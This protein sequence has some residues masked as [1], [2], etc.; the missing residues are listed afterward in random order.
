[1]TKINPDAK[2]PEGKRKALLI[3]GGVIAFV[4]FVFV[5]D[6]FAGLGLVG[7]GLAL[8]SG[9]ESPTTENAANDAVLKGPALQAKQLPVA[10]P[11]GEIEGDEEEEAGD[12]GE[13]EEQGGGEEEGDEEEDEQGALDLGPGRAPILLPDATETVE[14]VARALDNLQGWE[15]TEGAYP[16]SSLLAYMQHKKE[17]VS[18]AALAFA[19]ETKVYA[20]GF[21]AARATEIRARSRPGVV[22]RYLLRYEK[23]KPDVY[24]EVSKL[25]GV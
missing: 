24:A 22:R 10:A 1:M 9:E 4:L 17:W 7:S 14:N 21:L 20:P 15:A 6:T 12:E 23:S 25:L 2:L 8:V 18:V 3:G 19:V 13:E 11:V 16:E 5:V